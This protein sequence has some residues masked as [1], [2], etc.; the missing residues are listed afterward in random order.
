MK[1]TQRTDPDR[2]FQHFIDHYG[3]LLGAAVLLAGFALIG[4][5]IIQ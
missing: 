1:L 4:Y 3:Y 5:L 2:V